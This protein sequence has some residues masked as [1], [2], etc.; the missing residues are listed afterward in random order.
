MLARGARGSSGAARAVRFRVATGRPQ[1]LRYFGGGRAKRGVLDV[2]A[3][4][5]IPVSKETAKLPASQKAVPQQ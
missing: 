2:R 4:I 5:G 3:A 1:P